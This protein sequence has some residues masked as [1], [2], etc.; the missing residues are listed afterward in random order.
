MRMINGHPMYVLTQKEVI[1]KIIFFKVTERWT[2]KS[3]FCFVSCFTSLNIYVETY[4]F[5]I[6]SVLLCQNV[7][8]C[9]QKFLNVITLLQ[10]LYL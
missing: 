2:Q 6:R 9:K 8:E 7:D 5:V 1:S 3:I 4:N 10:N